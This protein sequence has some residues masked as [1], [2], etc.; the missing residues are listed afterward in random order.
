MLC[1]WVYEDGSLFEPPEK[2]IGFVYELCCMKTGKKYVGKKILHSRKI[3]QK[4]GI[5][6]K[7]KCDSDW[8]TYLGSSEA[9]VAHIEI[10]GAENIQRTVLHVCFDKASMSYLEMKE[11]VLRDA[12]ISDEYVNG[13]VMCRVTRPHLTKYKQRTKEDDIK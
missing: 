5:K 7:V 10:H 2:A 9:Y 11:Q 3:K 13:W 12:I 4:N 8:R 1:D 6:K